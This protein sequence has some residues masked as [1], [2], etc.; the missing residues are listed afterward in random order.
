MR[1]VKE[2]VMVDE[3]VTAGNQDVE[4]L[5]EE[6]DAA[7]AQ[8]DRLERDAANAA[9]R[10]DAAAADADMLRDQVR[11]SAEEADGL[12]TQVE[13]ASAQMREATGRYRDLAVRSEPGLP[14]ELVG[15]DTID[16]I[17]ASLDTARALAERMRR[18]IAEEAHA[19][20]VPAGA[21]E[22]READVSGMT[23]EQKIRYGL[24]RRQEA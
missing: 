16:A 22:R 20:R 3:P 7:R 11:R 14:S 5:R 12:R 2:W 19:A 10:A 15:G 6:L 21:P 4:G 17:D 13:A 23:A 9:A 18:Q 24:S 1:D 8:I